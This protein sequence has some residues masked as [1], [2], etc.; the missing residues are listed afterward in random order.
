MY[1]Y[2]RTE[3]IQCDV[4]VDELPAGCDVLL[5]YG[6]CQ[7]WHVRRYLL[8][9]FGLQS[10][11]CRPM[12]SFWLS[13]QLLDVRSAKIRVVTALL[14]CVRRGSI[15][16]LT[17]G[18]VDSIHVVKTCDNLLRVQIF[19]CY[20]KPSSIVRVLNRTKSCDFVLFDYLSTKIQGDPLQTTS[21]IW[22]LNAQ[23]EYGQVDWWC[24]VTREN[25]LAALY[26]TVCLY[27]MLIFRRRIKS[28]LPFAGIFR[29]LPYSTRFQDKG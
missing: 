23:K 16:Y 17:N 24:K 9:F 5:M 13:C 21:Y 12:W 26:S 10:V 7:I 6:E 2:G 18:A 3:C 22:Y 1:G 25:C 15:Q 27:G 8:I 29:R 14:I 19:N 20:F 11:W 28:R 4:H